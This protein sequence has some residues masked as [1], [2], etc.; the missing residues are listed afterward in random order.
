MPLHRLRGL[1]QLSRGQQP[2]F[3]CR[4]NFLLIFVS[5]LVLLVCDD[6]AEGSPRIRDG[7]DDKLGSLLRA[8]RPCQEPPGLRWIGQQ[9]DG[10]RCVPLLNPQRTPARV[11]RRRVRAGTG[12]TTQDLEATCGESQDLRGALRK[13]QVG[14]RN[15]GPPSTND[16]RIGWCSPGLLTSEQMPVSPLT[17]LGKGDQIMAEDQRFIW[18][19]FKECDS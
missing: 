14:G 2:A 1:T 3:G 10:S 18:R 4:N 7:S 19:R 8:L 9:R 16:R 5:P 11:N 15:H 17:H 13:R 6:A 12:S